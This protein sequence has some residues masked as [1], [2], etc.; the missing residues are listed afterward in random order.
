MILFAVGFPQQFFSKKNYRTLGN[1]SLLQYFHGFYTGTETC[2]YLN[3]Y[4]PQTSQYSLFTDMLVSFKQKAPLLEA[5]FSHIKYSETLKEKFLQANVFTE[6]L[7][8]C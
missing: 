5:I 4:K 6:E 1:S 7:S 8:N 3:E 2:Y